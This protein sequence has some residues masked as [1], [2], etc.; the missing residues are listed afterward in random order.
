V[1]H[2]PP[3]SWVCRSFIGLI[4]C[5]FTLIPDALLA[6]KAVINSDLVL[7]I[8]GRKVFPIGFTLPPP[9]DGKTPDGKNGIAELASAGATFMRTGGPWTPA[10]LEREQKYMDAAARYGMHCLPFL[11]ENAA[12]TSPQREA[13]LRQLINR[14]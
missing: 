7:V 11:R 8:D 4:L 5:I 3:Q 9:P 12:V 13:Q 14:F 10:T 6:N 2:A 1:S